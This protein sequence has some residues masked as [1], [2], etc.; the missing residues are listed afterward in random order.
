MLNYRIENLCRQVPRSGRGGFGADAAGRRASGV[1]CQVKSELVHLIA[2]YWKMRSPCG[3]RN[4]AGDCDGALIC[5]LYIKAQNR[6]RT[7]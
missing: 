6:L 4:N 5:T 3:I 1:V 7:S 2:A